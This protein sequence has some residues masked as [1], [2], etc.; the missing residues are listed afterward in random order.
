MSPIEHPLEFERPLVELEYQLERLKDE[1]ASGNQSRRAEYAA[2]ETKVT[3]IRKEIYGKL[4]PYQRV[5]LSRH[6]D[7]PFTLDYV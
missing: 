5:Q 2:L 4:S 7:R 6:F 1:L 3:K